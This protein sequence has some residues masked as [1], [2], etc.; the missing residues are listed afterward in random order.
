MKYNEILCSSCRTIKSQTEFANGYGAQAGRKVSICKECCNAK[1]EK[2]EQ[3]VGKVGAFWLLMAELGIP[4]I[5][6]VY[7]VAYHASISIKK[8]AKRPDLVEL[9]VKKLNLLDM[10]YDGFW[11]SDTMLDDILNEH[12]ETLD[13]KLDLALMNRIWGKYPDDKYAEAYDFLEDRFN[14]YTKDILDMDAN[15]TNRYRDLCKAEYQKRVADESGDIG[16]IQKAQKV[17]NDMLALLKLNNFQDVAKSDAQIAFEKAI[18]MIEY[19]KPAEC[20]E[21][22][23]YVDMCGHERDN[24]EMMRC[25][26]NAI[27]GTRDYPEIP[28]DER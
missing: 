22:D 1:L 20:E 16:E 15:L 14:E 6:Q 8:G 27:A 18:A 4:F 2:Y 19:T 5:Q 13:P 3:R 23:K 11:D 24:A 9:Y 25:L 21:L 28:R 7:D 12:K 26:R 17:V 10:K